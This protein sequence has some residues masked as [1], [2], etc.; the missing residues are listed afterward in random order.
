M[1]IPAKPVGL[2]DSTAAEQIFL[3]LKSKQ[4]VIIWD[5]PLFRLEDSRREKVTLQIKVKLC[6]L[7]F[8]YKNS[9]GFEVAPF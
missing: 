7:K 5:Q 4:N 3:L 9:T 8:L 6:A 1:E 2:S